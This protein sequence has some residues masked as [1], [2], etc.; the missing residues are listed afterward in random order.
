M[1]YTET[2]ITSQTRHRLFVRHYCPSVGRCG[3]TVMIVHGAA[4]HGDR[5][6]RVAEWL[7]RR[8][9]DVIVSDH[10]GHG[11]S[12][13]VRMHVDEF[14]QYARDQREIVSHFGLS[15]E[16]TAMVG[17]SMGGL[18]GIRFAQLFPEAAG[19]LVLLSPLLGVKVPI[20]RHTL[21]LARLLSWFLPT[22]RFRS[23]IEPDQVSRCPVSIETRL[24]D[25]LTNRDV[26]AGWFFA[27]KWAIGQAHEDAA[28]LTMPMLLLQAGD[29]RLVDPDAHVEWVPKV[30][31]KDVTVARLEG[32]LHELLNEPDW[33]Q[34]AGRIIDWLEA[35]W[36]DQ[37]FR[38]R[39]PDASRV[40]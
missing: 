12:E 2:F 37:G 39:E 15:A 36:S 21:V 3:R 11:L 38:R 17:H 29:D 24:N 16:R 23:R 8:G 7:V 4:E 5:Y 20:G 18:V 27:M 9:W 14:D 34:T 10:R 26:T 32:C 25:P 6:G 28:R 40:A 19:A 1:R 30:G 35:R 31:S 22:F 33:E 13:G